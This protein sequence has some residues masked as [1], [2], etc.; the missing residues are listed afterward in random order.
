MSFHAL[1]PLLST[2]LTHPTPST[3]E[4]SCLQPGKRRSEALSSSTLTKTPPMPRSY[5][6]FR[7]GNHQTIHRSPPSCLIARQLASTSIL[8]PHYSK[9]LGETARGEWSSLFCFYTA[10]VHLQCNK[11][12]LPGLPHGFHPCPWEWFRMLRFSSPH[13]YISSISRVLGSTRWWGRV[14]KA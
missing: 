10:H 12:L 13:V 6:C 14:Y 4:Y 9:T 2:L 1:T 5:H 3:C 11:P 8:T 7:Y